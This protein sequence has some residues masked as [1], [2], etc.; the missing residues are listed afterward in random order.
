M[1]L[2]WQYFRWA[3]CLGLPQSAE[4]LSLDYCSNYT[5]L[6][7]YLDYLYN[8]FFALEIFGRRLKSVNV[9]LLSFSSAVLKLF[10]LLELLV[11]L[12]FEFTS[13]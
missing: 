12:S 2:V 7:G 9:R 6:C 1:A 11:F 10:Y 8:P 13:L 4:V 3:V 5:F